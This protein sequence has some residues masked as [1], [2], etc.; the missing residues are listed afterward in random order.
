MIGVGEW[1]WDWCLP[2]QCGRRL[3]EWWEW[4]CGLEE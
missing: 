1:E 3:E 2:E 4:S